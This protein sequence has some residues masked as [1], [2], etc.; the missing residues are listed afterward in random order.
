M[1]QIVVGCQADKLG[2]RRRSKERMTGRQAPGFLVQ[3][4]Q[5]GDGLNPGIDKSIQGLLRILV[6]I[7][8][9]PG[10]LIR[11]CC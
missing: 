1:N 11:I 7:A 2:Q 10:P 5:T 4:S 6:K 9:R 8:T 3:S